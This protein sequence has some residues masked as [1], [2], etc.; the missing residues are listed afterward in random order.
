MTDKQAKQTNNTFSIYPDDV[1][2]SLRVRSNTKPRDI[3][4]IQPMVSTV[5]QSMERYSIAISKNVNKTAE[6][7]NSYWLQCRDYVYGE[8]FQLGA[9]C[10]SS[11]LG[12]FLLV[13]KRKPLLRY[14]LPVIVGAGLTGYAYVRKEWND[15]DLYSNIIALQKRTPLP[16]EASSKRIQSD[17]EDNGTNSGNV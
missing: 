5:R 8:K 16:E 7:L 17:S 12:T 13:R 2:E 9:I 1:T 11:L 14:S 3:P 15:F 4:Y 6:K 10:V